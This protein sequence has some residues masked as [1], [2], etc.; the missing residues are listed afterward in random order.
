M[1]EYENF[2]VQKM[3]F[4][5]NWNPKHRQ[6]DPVPRRV[7]FCISSRFWTSS[8][9]HFNSAPTC[10][11]SACN[12]WPKTVMHPCFYPSSAQKGGSEFD[13]SL[14]DI[15]YKERHCRNN[16]K[17]LKPPV[18]KIIR[19]RMKRNIFSLKKHRCERATKISEDCPQ[20][21]WILCFS[22]IIQR[23]TSKTETAGHVT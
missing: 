17:C 6:T 16:P 9:L 10:E 2:V 20:V 1:S 8:R 11:S 18:K 22:G 23:E 7:G 4:V 5:T 14:H 12:S 3:S 19:K 15:K 21:I 13:L